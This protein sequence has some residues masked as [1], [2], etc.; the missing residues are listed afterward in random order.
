MQAVL[1]PPLQHGGK[2]E[3]EREKQELTPRGSARAGGGGGGTTR[4]PTL[5]E[6]MGEAAALVTGGGGGGGKEAESLLQMWQSVW[7]V[8]TAD[9]DQTPVQTPVQTPRDELH[10][11][12]H[13][14]RTASPAKSRCL[15]SAASTSARGDREVLREDVRAAGVRGERRGEGAT[16]EDAGASPASAGGGSRHPGRGGTGG[17]ES[18]RGRDMRPRRQLYEREA[19]ESEPA[20]PVIAT[21]PVLPPRMDSSSSSRDS[22]SAIASAREEYEFAERMRRRSHILKSSVDTDLCV[23]YVLGH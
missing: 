15:M 20:S 6:K 17:K 4:A 16:K 21:P 14:V 12:L 10:G 18:P 8:P 11:G 9:Q 5:L 7:Y 1:A 13:R 22:R 23:M 2:K 19:K 3:G